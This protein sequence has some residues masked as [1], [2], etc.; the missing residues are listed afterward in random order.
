MGNHVGW[1]PTLIAAE[2]YPMAR[3]I[4]IG[5]EREIWVSP[6]SV[7][8]MSDIEYNVANSGVET[9]DEV[10][11]YANVLTAQGVTATDFALVVEKQ[12]ETTADTTVSFAGIDV[13]DAACT[14]QAIIKPPG[15]SPN[16]TWFFTTGFAWDIA[17]T[18]SPA[19]QVKTL[20][21]NGHTGGTIS[22]LGAL[23]VVALPPM[24]SFR[25]ISCVTSIEFASPIHPALAIPCGLDGA[26]GGVKPGRTEQPTMSLRTKDAGLASGLA[27][28]GGA[29]CTVMIVTR[30]EGKL[31]TERLF[32]G[33]AY[34]TVK[35][36]SGD[37]NDE[38]QVAVDGLYDTMVY[39]PAL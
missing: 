8:K 23:R 35:P 30:K 1:Q 19:K 29:Y 32:L 15:Y 2:N 17:N 3:K 36:S 22:A 39:F 10:N 11:T 20:G 16:R 7:F 33:N 14:C 34:F 5:G 31:E 6:K 12:F 38:A 37:G 25:K 9:A 26:G 4:T 18:G 13:D 28:Y 27:R 21:Y 24:I